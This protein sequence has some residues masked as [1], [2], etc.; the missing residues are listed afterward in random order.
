MKNYFFGFASNIYQALIL[1]VFT[2]ILIHLLGIEGYALFSLLII[3]SVIFNLFDFGITGSI[4][5]EFSNINSNNH[6]SHCYIR[7]ME[8]YFIVFGFLLSSL[9]TFNSNYIISNFI[10]TSTLSIYELNNILNIIIWSVFFRWLCIFYKGILI[11]SQNFNFV[12]I[13]N[14]I[15]NTL[16]IPVTVLIFKKDNISLLD[17]FI[18]QLLISILE[19]L[20]LIIYI[21]FKKKYL[22]FFTV[23]KLEFSKNIDKFKFSGS[24]IITSFAS[25]LLVHFDKILISTNMNIKYFGYYSIISLVISVYSLFSNTV[26]SITTPKLVKLYSNNNIL[27]YKE[28]YVG[29]TQLY[30]IFGS[31]LTFTLIYFSKEIF[32]FWIGDN[33]FPDEFIDIHNYLVISAF[34]SLLLSL[35][36]QHQFSI[37]KMFLHSRMVIFYSLIYFIFGYLS[38]KLFSIVG[39]VLFGFLINIIFFIFW[40]KYCHNFYKIINHRDWIINGILFPLYPVVFLYFFIY[41]CTFIINLNIIYIFLLF[42]FSIFFSFFSLQTKNKYFIRKLY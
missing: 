35:Q 10:K 27:E 33:I 12:Y 36:Y 29:I 20:F 2:P 19:F 6:N 1:M 7:T 21:Y 39:I 30:T 9:L 32:S 37:G 4:T 26:S 16:K 38:F 34:L 24:L 22:N 31:C 3:I 13:S 25:A 11:G 18:Y 40:S 17:F 23:P 5:R 15:F 8:L 28:M 41:F 42:I 14:I